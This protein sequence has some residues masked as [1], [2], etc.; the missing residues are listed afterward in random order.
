MNSTGDRYDL[1]LGGDRL[2]F[3]VVSIALEGAKYPP[4]S[5]IPLTAALIRSSET[6]SLGIPAS[7]AGVPVSIQK[8]YYI[9]ERKKIAVETLLTVS[10]SEYLRFLK[11]CASTV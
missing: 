10:V 2:L 9:T 7:S 1:G 11:P 4:Q 8:L 5:I 3:F 6:L